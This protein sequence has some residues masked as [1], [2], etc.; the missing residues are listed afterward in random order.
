MEITKDKVKRSLIVGG[1][2]GGMS[3]YLSAAVIN[4]VDLFIDYKFQEFWDRFNYSL[5]HPIVNITNALSTEAF[6][7]IQPFILCGMAILA[8]KVL[9]QKPNK[10]EDASEFGSYGTSRWATTSEIFDSSNIASSFKSQGNI[11]GIHNRKAII[12]HDNSQLNRNIAITGG[13]GAGKTASNIIPNILHNSEKSI[14]VIDPKGELYEKTS[15]AKRKQGYD[16]HLINFKD[17][18][19]SDRYNLFDYIRRD[20]DANKIAT[21]MV[22][23]SGE[24]K[25][26][27]D[28]WNLKQI[29]LIATFILYVKYTLPKEQH[30]MGSVYNISQLKPRALFE[31]FQAYPPEHIVRKSFNSAVSNLNEKTFGD[32]FSTM[33]NTLN[34]WTYEDVCSFTSDN[35]FLFEELGTKKKIV[36]VIIPIAD[37]EFKP[38]ITTFFTQLFSELYLFADKHQGVLPKGVIL[39]L[40]EFA[41][42]G[43]I[44]DFELRLST[45]RSLG[46]EV[47]I[48]LQDI[49]QLDNRYSKEVAKEILNNCDI[50][51][52]MKANEFDTA[53]YFSQELGKTTIKVKNQSSSS[54]SK[55]SS[56]SESVQHMGRDLMTPAE[57]QL[58]KKN[59][60]LVFISG[61]YPMKVKKAW[62]FKTKY[63]KNLLTK[64]VKRE[65][66]PVADRGGYQVFTYE[67]PE[68]FDDM[69]IID[70][71]PPEVKVVDSETGEILVDLKPK[72]VSP[73]G[74][75]EETKEEIK[76]DKDDANKSVNDLLKNFNINEKI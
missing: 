38:L 72:N 69:I 62:Y 45:T 54:S 13:S 33:N 51:I 61:Q 25:V 68:L 49:S 53:K 43:K 55:S 37:N 20:S 16:V 1:L 57:I 32:V 12:Q 42:C 17:R 14:V 76:E 11:L 36:Y 31:L 5:S 50:R 65:D 74:M 56:K 22:A 58:M 60:Q 35:D 24:G 4:N 48:V 2:S 39:Y 15:E 41:N 59:E 63:F 47:T 40:D 10:F 66:Y 75:R 34:P 44:P 7:Q 28:F 29:A 8:G 30:H 9:F 21:V 3:E 18:Y 27:M 23:N 6:T 19:N 26:K 64:H 70:D 71:E 52:L 67:E 46:I 73:I